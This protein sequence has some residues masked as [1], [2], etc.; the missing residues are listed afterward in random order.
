MRICT[1]KPVIDDCDTGVGN[2]LSDF[3]S[4]IAPQM[5]N[6]NYSHVRSQTI[7]SAG[8]IAVHDSYALMKI[9]YRC[10]LLILFWW[11]SYQI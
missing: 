2:T 5:C 10:I 8:S 6:P 7:I 3:L 1:A 9:F 4:S 11:T